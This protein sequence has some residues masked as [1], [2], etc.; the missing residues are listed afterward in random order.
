MVPQWLRR[1]SNSLRQSALGAFDYAQIVM[2]TRW[3]DWDLLRL[4]LRRTGAEG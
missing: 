4:L 3:A 1:D 2:D